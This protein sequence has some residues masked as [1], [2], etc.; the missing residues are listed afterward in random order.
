MSRKLTEM[1]KK[2]QEMLKELQKQKRRFY[3]S[4]GE[5]MKQLDL[6]C[7][8]LDE[9]I[10]RAKYEINLSNERIAVL[11]LEIDEYN[12]DKA[13]RD[14]KDKQE[15]DILRRHEEY[16]DLTELIENLEGEKV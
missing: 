13:I 15:A 16:W 10:Y 14:A 9:E 7:F 2:S 3:L 1:I 6:K 4:I 12:K 8:K 5:D 11:K